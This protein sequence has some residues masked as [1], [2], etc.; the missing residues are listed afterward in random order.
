ICIGCDYAAK[1]RGMD[2]CPF[3]RTPHSDS[4]NEADQ[5]AM[6]QARV[7]KKDP[8]AIHFLGEAY[9]HGG[10]FGLQ[11]DMRKA[12]ELW[13]EAAEL[14]S[15]KALCNLGVAYY[16]GYG[17]QQDMAKGV[18]FLSEA[19][20]KGD[21]ES[22]S[23]L[24]SIEVEK[25]NLD[26]A[27]RHFLISAKMGY[28][29]SLEMITKLFANGIATKE[30]YAEALK[31]YQDAV[32]EMKSR[33]RDNAK[34]CLIRKH[35][36]KEGSS[37]NQLE[38]PDDAP[39]QSPALFVH[40]AGEPGRGGVRSSEVDRADERGLGHVPRRLVRGGLEHH[41]A[42]ADRRDDGDLPPVR[43]GIQHGLER[44]GNVSNDME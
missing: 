27:L 16:N 32:N 8:Y 2:D 12:V 18:E 41:T 25:G 29:N 13:T 24:G 5:L 35:G 28:K 30:Q 26:R 6:I 7:L 3:C 43:P 21:V 22:R 20:M 15:A 11:K 9:C 44:E 17:V 42:V 33:D 14:G 34:A 39:E 38:S 23:K 19:A 36:I 4:E 40:V 31:G 37:R 10:E 1:K